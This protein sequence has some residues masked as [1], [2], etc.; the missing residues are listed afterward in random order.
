M[1][2]RLNLKRDLIAAR[3]PSSLRQYQQATFDVA[4]SLEVVARR[5]KCW[6]FYHGNDLRRGVEKLV[7][8]RVKSKRFC[9]KLARLREATTERMASKSRL[10]AAYNMVTISL[11][12]KTLKKVELAI[13]FICLLIR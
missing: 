3:L 11:T 12:R 8:D 10:E 1:V 13:S 7:K 6:S 5:R 4:H 9:S 2:T